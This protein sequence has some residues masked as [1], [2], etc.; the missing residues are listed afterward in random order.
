MV[1]ELSVF[2]GWK[3][4]SSA[5]IAWI[6]RTVK[7][8]LVLPRSRT[9]YTLSSLQ[10]L[11]QGSSLR[12]TTSQQKGN[13][14]LVVCLCEDITILSCSNTTPCAVLQW[15]T[16][17]VPRRYLPHLS[18]LSWSWGYNQSR[19]SGYSLCSHAVILHY[20][21]TAQLIGYHQIGCQV[22]N[23]YGKVGSWASPFRNQPGD[24]TRVWVHDIATINS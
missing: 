6:S 8:A 9:G 13:N 20:Q 11:I 18:S 17:R 2:F 14:T 5:Q 7:T 15:C 3:G 12:S 10:C 22:V 16:T 4:A 19:L 1:S 24:V 21:S 23:C